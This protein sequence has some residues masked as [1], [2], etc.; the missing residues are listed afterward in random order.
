MAHV[1]G[2][3]LICVLALGACSTPTAAPYRPPEPSIEA[4]APGTAPDIVVDAPRLVR[5]PGLEIDYVANGDGEIYHLEGRYYCYHDG[6][7]FF[8][9]TMSGDWRH[10]QMKYVPAD[11]FRVRG[12]LPPGV[13]RHNPA[14]AEPVSASLL[15][16]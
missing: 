2:L 12:R 1:R 16:D 10:V 13:M 14:R 7:W 4:A 11:L 8:S 9:P 15:E 3:G 5:Y 6:H